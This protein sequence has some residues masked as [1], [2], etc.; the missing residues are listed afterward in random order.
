MN[1]RFLCCGDS[2]LVVE[3]GTH[4]DRTLNDRVLRLN[5]T[6][7]A[8]RIAGIVETVPTFRSLM[9]QYDP[10]VTDNTAVRTAIEHLLDDQHDTPRTRKLW[11]IPA[12]YA[13]PHGPDLAEVA[14]RTGLAA[15]EVV[16]LHSERRYH[17]YMVGFSPGYP[18][19]GDLVEQLTLPRRTDP[20]VRVPRGSIA[21]AAG[22]YEEERTVMTCGMP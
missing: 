17:I 18:Y 21:I 10:L 11:R 4:I 14:Q 12:C 16:R 1:V 2:A 19:M 13:A 5:T 20:R 9:V 6:V 22:G 15:A 7:R 3:L 8:A